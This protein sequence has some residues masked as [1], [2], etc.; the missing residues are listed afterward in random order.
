MCWLT[1]N[2]LAEPKMALSWAKNA[3]TSKR[4]QKLFF[5]RFSPA[6]CVAFHKMFSV[7]ADAGDVLGERSSNLCRPSSMGCH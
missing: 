1:N 4:P 5:S 3:E 2:V 6:I 7:E